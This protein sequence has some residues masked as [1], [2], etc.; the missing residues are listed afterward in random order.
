MDV[1]IRDDKQYEKLRLAEFRE[2]GAC[3]QPYQGQNRSSNRPGS[4]PYA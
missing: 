4:N 2:A 1:V 3:S